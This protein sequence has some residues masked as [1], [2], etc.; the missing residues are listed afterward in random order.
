MA[1]QACRSVHARGYNNKD[2]HT[3]YYYHE[4]NGQLMH[5]KSTQTIVETYE[6][7]EGDKY[8][9]PEQIVFGFHMIA[10]HGLIKTPE[11]WNLIVPQVKKQMSTLDRQT[12]GSLARAVEGASFMYL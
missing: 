3:A 4:I 5:A 10:D 8:M 12:V 1:A 2:D 9:T 7:W 6:K 11:F